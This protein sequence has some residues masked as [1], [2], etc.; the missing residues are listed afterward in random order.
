M[1]LWLSWFIVVCYVSFLELELKFFFIFFTLLFLDFTWHSS[2]IL[3]VL[4]SCFPFAFTLL[5]SG[6]HAHGWFTFCFLG[7]SSV[8]FYFF[9]GFCF[10]SIFFDKS[11]LPFPFS[12]S[13]ILPVLIF[14]PSVHPNLVLRFSFLFRKY[15]LP[16]HRGFCHLSGSSDFDQD[17]PFFV[18]SSFWFN[19]LFF[20]FPLFFFFFFILF[21]FV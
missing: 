21:I 20:V 1:K 4:Y 19:T 3:D 13:V 2:W 14:L 17:T 8:F 16:F 10:W 5:S 6:I 9:P 7:F 15:L 18:L 12:W 11:L